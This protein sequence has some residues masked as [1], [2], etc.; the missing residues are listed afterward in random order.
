MPGRHGAGGVAAGD[1]KRDRGLV[2]RGRHSSRAPGP[3][4]TPAGEAAGT[5]TGNEGRVQ[6]VHPGGGPVVEERPR[7]PAPEP[8]AP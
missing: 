7:T 5:A 8:N 4:V 3:P 2:P 6:V 1:G